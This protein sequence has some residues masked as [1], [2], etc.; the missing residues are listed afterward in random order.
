M[1][2]FSGFL[3]A[4]LHLRTE[5]DDGTFANEDGNAL[6][7]GIDDQSLSALQVL[8]RVE[9]V[10]TAL[11]REVNRAVAGLVVAHRTGHQRRTEHPLVADVLHAAVAVEVHHQSSHQRVVLEVCPTGQRIEVGH[12]AI[13]QLVVVDERLVGRMLV[14]CNVPDFTQRPLAVSTEQRDE[15]T[16]LVPTR[17]QLTPFFQVFVLLTRLVEELLGSH[18]AILHAESSLVH[19]PEGHARHRVVQ[20]GRHLRTHILPAS[21]DVAAPRGGGIA[22]LA[23]KAATG[24]QEHARLV[25]LSLPD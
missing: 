13:A 21:A 24:E 2:E 22:L 3:V 1:D 5:R 19:T 15:G 23:G 16:K 10:P 20:S 8:T 7:G 12:E 18:I 4:P 14:G 17:L 11:L 25:L 6:I 9:I